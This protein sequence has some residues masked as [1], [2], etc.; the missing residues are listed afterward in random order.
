MKRRKYILSLGA[1]AAGASAIFG[2]NAFTSVEANRNVS[3]AVADD[4]EAF[5][6]LTQRG[7]GERSET[8]GGPEKIELQ[9]PGDDEGDYP[10]GNPTDPEGL[11][12]D[13]VYRFAGDAAHDEAG[14]FGVHNQGTQPVEVYSTQS[15]TSDIP[16]VTIFDVETGDLLTESDRSPKLGTG[17]KL[18]CGLKVDTHGVAANNDSYDISLTINAVAPQ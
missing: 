9:L 14:L 3:V 18:L 16:S 17:E 2:S 11:G 8:D 6:K 13:S 10:A 1:T 4:D 12:T 7:S 5:L 15:V